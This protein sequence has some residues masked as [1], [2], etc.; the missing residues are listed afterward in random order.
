MS[1]WSN[2]HGTITV[3]T[4]QYFPSKEDLEAY[5]V[6]ATSEIYKRSGGITGSEGP[7][8]IYVN[9]W[10]NPRSYGPD[11]AGYSS[12]YITVQGRLRD[13]MGENTE[14]EFIRFVNRLKTFVSIEH[15]LVEIN[16]LNY[17]KIFTTSTN[18]A[19]SHNFNQQNTFYHITESTDDFVREDG[20]I[21]PA[22]EAKSDQL[23]RI[24]ELNFER[25]IN[26]VFDDKKIDKIKW[27]LNHV[28][29]PMFDEI[30][31]YN[32]RITSYDLDG[33]YVRRRLD[34]KLPV[35]KEWIEITEND[36]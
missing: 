31:D 20:E 6:Y 8:E 22:L 27:I 34:L 15:M 14:E 3:E 24:A 4:R 16:S 11:G 23:Y 21:D 2:I 19:F 36:T 5:I 12:A 30:M 28:T 7:A 10:R 9:A 18:L 25:Y 29:I 1:I 35:P 32:M 26:K 13:R 17:Q 33:D